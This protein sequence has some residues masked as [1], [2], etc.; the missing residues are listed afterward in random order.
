MSRRPGQH[1]KTTSGY[2]ARHAKPGG[3][4]PAA[5]IGTA[6]KAGTASLVAGAAGSAL[7]LSGTATAAS[8]ATA[9]SPVPAG[10]VNARLV[11]A[12]LISAGV[13]NTGA[14]DLA[15]LKAARPHVVVHRTRHHQAAGHSAAARSTY[16]VR[17]GDSLS[18]ISAKFCGTAADFPSLAAASG[19]AN[20]NLIF[21]GQSI[22]LNCH[23][24]VPAPTA[25]PAHKAHVHT[26][27]A[28]HAHHDGRSADHTR[29]AGRH[30]AP[31]R[32][33]RNPGHVGTAGMAAFEAC[34]ISRESGGN[35]RAVNP[36][37]GAGGL[38]QFLPSTW[39]SLGY[40]SAYPGGAQTAPVSVQ[41]AAFAK[42][43]AEAGTS[44][45]APYDGC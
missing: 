24:A 16:I 25:L 45:W 39:A 44:P 18:R 29:P 4:G 10:L 26:R 7:A 20:P 21:P 32:H 6:A 12:N 33:A 13:V 27:P 1:A 34:V 3:P 9:P 28:R 11:N 43:F 36:S 30:K 31:G 35:P 17:S 2:D 38:F 14:T 23:A 19:I 5:L 40:A 41:E 37:S 15:A 22:T 8:A 42:L